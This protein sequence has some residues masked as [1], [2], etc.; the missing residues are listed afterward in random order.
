LQ[1]VICDLTGLPNYLAEYTVH[2]LSPC[3]GLLTAVADL[4]S[5]HGIGVVKQC[6]QIVKYNAIF[7]KNGVILHACV[8]GRQ[9]HF[10]RGG[11]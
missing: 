1:Y 11:Y 7:Y 6:F 2:S 5:L 4:L 10:S 8:H 9:K 3:F